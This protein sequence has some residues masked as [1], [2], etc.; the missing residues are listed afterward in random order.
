MQ[1]EYVDLSFVNCDKKKILKKRYPLLLVLGMALFITIGGSLFL[2]LTNHKVNKINYRYREP[3][4]LTPARSLI[5]R[6]RKEVIGFLPSWMVARGSI[7]HIDELSQIIYF[8]LGVNG[9]GEIIKYGLDNNP[10]AE[11]QYLRSDYMK[12]IINEA[13]AKDIKVLITIKNFDNESI[14]T[15]LSNPIY[16]D[17]FMRQLQGLIKEYKF[18]GINLDFEYF[19][20]SDFPTKKYLNPF[21][22]KVAGSLKKDNPQLI[23]SLDV[24]ASVVMNDRAY[25]MVK[26]GEIVD[27]VIVMGY[28]FR[29]ANAK[30]A[31][32]TAPLYAPG[33]QISID[34]SIQSLNGR[35]ANEKVILAVPFYGY[36]WETINDGYQSETVENSGALATY[37]R[38]KQLISSRKDIEKHWDDWA[39]APWLSYR[40]SGAIKHIY[41][42]DS[43]SINKKLN[44]IK[45]QKLGGVA[46]F[47]LG[48]EGD[49][50]EL[51][52]T[53]SQYRQ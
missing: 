14:D 17:T 25:D 21:L 39:M 48:Y 9:N 45:E 10:V 16:S 33:N 52:E 29:S 11:W 7:I 26:I 51:W 40:Q 41:Y 18:D 23:I 13:K 42:D 6:A 3:T 30:R 15:L 44:Y 20:D 1:E 50:Q 38:I 19:S 43:E 8:G 35:V 2:I 24:N 4:P 49:T 22:E 27:Q 37:M 47:A 36:E 53:I 46:I 12:N 28:D 31:G 34:R 5:V 32:F